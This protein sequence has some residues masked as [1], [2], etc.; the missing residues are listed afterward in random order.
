M[1]SETESISKVASD[2][3][4]VMLLDSTHTLPK[5]GQKL[6]QLDFI[7]FSEY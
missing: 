4:K 7:R 1:A 2:N 5:P 6:F 3:M